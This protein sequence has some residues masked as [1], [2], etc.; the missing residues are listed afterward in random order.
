[1]HTSATAN[2]SA[3]ILGFFIS[4]SSTLYIANPVT[5]GVD[6]LN[7]LDVR[8]IIP[9]AKEAFHVVPE[10]LIR[11]LLDT[12]QGLYCRWTLVC[13]LEVPDEHGT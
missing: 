7:V 13:T 8:D 6:D 10:A 11:L 9:S 3:T 5:E 2:R 4:I 1:M 12:L